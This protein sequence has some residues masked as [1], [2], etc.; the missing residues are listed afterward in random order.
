M[1]TEF[2]VQETKI[3]FIAVD[4]MNIEILAYYIG[5]KDKIEKNKD[6]IC[7]Y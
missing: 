4:M 1:I 2:I 3:L 7:S 6:K 5:L